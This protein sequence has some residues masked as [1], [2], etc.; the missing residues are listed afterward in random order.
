MT[1]DQLREDIGAL[2][3]NMDWV[4]GEVSAIRTDIRELDRFKWKLVGGATVLGVFLGTV[5]N[6]AM[7]L[8]GA[9]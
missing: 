4:R 1:T 7:Q 2:K 8:V 6:L 5:V 3:A 9:R